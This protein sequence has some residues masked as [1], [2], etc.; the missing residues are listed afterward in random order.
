[1]IRRVYHI[2]GF[3]CAAC[4]EKSERHL[5]GKS[6]ISSARI[7]FIGERLY[8]EF[9][10]KELSPLELK[11]II[12]EVE[13]DPVEIAALGAEKKKDHK[14]LF[15][16]LRV[17]Y[18]VFIFFLCGF[19]F[20]DLYWLRFGLYLS[21]LVVIGYDILYKV[22]DNIIHL[23]NPLD[24]YLLISLAS[25]G[26]FVLACLKVS[27]EGQARAF[28]NEVFQME[29]HF[30]AIL[31]CLL[32]QVGEVLQ[33]IAVR[34]SVKSIERAVDSKDIEA[35][36]KENGQL[37][38]VSAKTLE[39]GD[40]CYVNA[41]MAIPVDGEVV[42]GGGYCDTSSLTGESVPVF[43]ASGETVYSGTLLRQGEITLVAKKDFASSSSAKILDL[44]SESLE[45]KGK[46]ERF[47]TSFARV[48]TPV[49]FLIAIA[50]ILIAG[51]TFASWRNA[52]YS[53]LEIMVISCPCALVI[54][55]PLAYFASLGK[56][57]SKGILIKGASFL[58]E[59]LRVKT[60]VTDKTGTLTK[61]SFSMTEL[62][63]DPS[64]DDET[65][66]RIFASLE[67]ASSHP[68]AKAIASSLGVDTVAPKKFEI[69]PGLGI[70]AELEDGKTY[71]AGNAK[72]AAS[73]GI[74]VVDSTLGVRLFLF[75]ESS[76]L[77]YV[78]LEDQLKENSKNMVKSLQKQGIFTKIYSGDSAS[79]VEKV[80]Q[81]LGVDGYRA[82]L[83]PEDKLA[84]L[85]QEESSGPVLFLGDGVNDAPAL[86][87]ADIGVAM[88][89]LGA[90]LAIEEAD[91][92]LLND[93]PASLIEA[94]NVA[95]NN[96]RAIIA[97]V[98]FA[99]L[100]KAAVMVLA[101]VFGESLPMEVA[102]LADTGVSVICIL[103]SLL[104]LRRK[105]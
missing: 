64:I 92:L 22:F 95:K 62:V 74:D 89:A 88:G 44:V 10:E 90:D 25:T 23:R 105:A 55:V 47:I 26:A 19:L 70:Q 45:K 53:G 52:I 41:G 36:K 83:L 21:A 48:Y 37:V 40:V 16:L 17:A 42:E 87:R 71:F 28:G 8:V 4:A 27:S 60:L 51:F 18:C 32:W 91:I 79:N 61:G 63:V 65:F 102:V 9:E 97:N 77:G 35:L 69:L 84:L 72:L 67:S 30:E 56:A 39:E 82:E 2:S 78:T 58:D 15:L 73:R 103:N 96:R 76:C 12:A 43:V 5:Q 49:V 86:A 54:S 81:D 3:D 93:D 29:E 34:R 50:Y 33:T 68:L 80:A 104:L 14:V 94:M 57:S 38:R 6:C 7:D 101:M 11:K 1:M 20:K 98:G 100:V 13:S 59:L 66:K 85:E 31:V 46:A 99:L 24:E 75:S